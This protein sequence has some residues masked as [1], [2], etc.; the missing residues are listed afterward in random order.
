M[1]E[2]WLWFALAQVAYVGGSLNEPGGGHNILEP[3]ATDVATVLGKNY[4]NFQS[5]VD[6][7][8]SHD[9][10]LVA[11]DA[12]HAVAQMIDLINDQSR[13]QQQVDRAQQILHA[14]QG[15][16][17]RHITLID[18]YLILKN[19]QAESITSESAL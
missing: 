5:I 7:F 17:E 12:N 1:G 16:V 13:R 8:L 6:E 18:R 4:F 11:S 3:I 15:A 19:S 9:A 2:M 14:N 10:V